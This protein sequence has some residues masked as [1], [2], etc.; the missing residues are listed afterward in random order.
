MELKGVSTTVTDK[1]MKNF[2]SKMDNHTRFT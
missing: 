2:I 1:M